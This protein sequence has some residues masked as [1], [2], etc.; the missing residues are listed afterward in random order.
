VA[1]PRVHLHLGQRLLKPPSPGGLLSGLGPLPR[2][3]FSLVVK[4]GWAL[5]SFCLITP[6]RKRIMVNSCIHAYKTYILKLVEMLVAKFY[7][8]VLVVISP[9]FC[10]NVGG[11]NV[12]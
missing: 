3:C 8:Y 9:L 12:R 7:S 1:A 5:S 4:F 10:L 2:W 11:R 6:S